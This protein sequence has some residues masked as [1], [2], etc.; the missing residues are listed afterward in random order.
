MGWDEH[1]Y[2]HEDLTNFIRALPSILKMVP[3]MRN[4]RMELEWS[5]PFNNRKTRHTIE[6][7]KTIALIKDL[8]NLLRT[9][10]ALPIA[11]KTLS[12]W[13][14][15]MTYEE[16]IRSV[17]FDDKDLCSIFKLMASEIMSPNNNMVNQGLRA[18]LLAL[19]FSQPS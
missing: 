3:G 8:T 17:P 2:I 6:D 4:V 19:G 12:V 7:E 9:F 11:F 5:T 15:G 14:D 16:H 10:H 13:C 18:E 1:S